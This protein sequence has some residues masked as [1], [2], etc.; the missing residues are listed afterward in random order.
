MAE[1][2]K[3]EKAKIIEEVI[4]VGVPEDAPAKGAAGFLTGLLLGGALGALAA[5]LYAPQG[6][7]ET[8]GLIKQKTTDYTDLAKT[9]AA[10]IT[11]AAGDTADSAKAKAAEVADGVKAKAADLG[12]K[13]TGS[14]ASVK[15]SAQDLVDKSKFIAGDQKSRI[16]EAV[17][18]GKQAAQETKEQLTAQAE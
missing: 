15:D 7:D 4:V 12:A 18:A 9:K 6:G 13:V 3:P 2:N 1:Q 17:D 8:R 10:E 14:A 11:D 5:L 16:S